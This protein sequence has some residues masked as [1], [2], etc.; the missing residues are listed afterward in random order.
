MT[1]ASNTPAVNVANRDEVPAKWF[2]GAQ[3]WVHATAASTGG[4]LAV[5]EQVGSPGLQSP[6]HLHHNEDEA[7]F[8]IDGT[9]R[10]VSGEQSWQGSSGT[11]AYLPKGIPHGFE[12]VGEGEARFLLFLTPGGFESFVTELWEDAPSGPPD[13]EKVMKAAGN[14]GL[15]IL[16]PLPS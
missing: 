9:L 12:V 10:F 11:W 1:V 14:Y 8:I 7:F 5:I 13:M 6:Y 3:T 4:S 15:D 2:F 16:G